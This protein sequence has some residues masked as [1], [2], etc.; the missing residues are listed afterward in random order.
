MD[1]RI[2]SSDVALLLTIFLL[3]LAGLMS[4]QDTLSAASET[5]SSLS[6]GAAT[7]KPLVSSNQKQTDNKAT[8]VAANLAV[9]PVAPGPHVLPAAESV[10]G[11]NE[12]WKWYA[13]S[14]LVVQ[15]YPGLHA[16]YS[17]PNSLPTRGEVRETTSMD[18]YGGFR[19]WNRAEGHFDVLT[20]QGFGLNDTLGIEAFPN[21]EA[22]KAG[23]P[24]PRLNV[25]RLFVRQTINLDGRAGQELLSGDQLTLAGKQNVSR[26]TFTIGR[27]SL[28]DIFDNNAYAN[29]PR[30]QFMNWALMA[31]AAWDYPSD[32]LGYTTGAAAELNQP[33][34]ALRYGF[35]QI[36]RLRN[37]WTSEDHLFT[38]PAYRGAGDGAFW[39][40]WGMSSELE[41]RYRTNAHPGTIRFLTYLNR[42]RFGS[43]QS[44]LSVPGAD[45]SQTRAYRGKYGVGLNWEQEITRNIGLFSRL[46]WNDGRSEAWMFT[47]INHSASL[48]ISVK[49]EAWRRRE[50]TFGVAG[51]GSG[52]S[53]VNQEFLAAGGTGIL[54]G[55]GALNYGKEKLLETYYD[56]RVSRMLHAAVDYQFIDDPAF[57]RA[58]GPVTVFGTR[59]HWEF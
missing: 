59:L 36:D 28:K 50:D 12:I 13:Q 24:F 42:G 32:A 20:W 10:E 15:G 55:D 45:I 18:V 48:G 31:N 21:G 29:D 11:E 16:K 44:A 2:A 30:K 37:A 33:N 41:R 3:T 23:T 52:I 5:P 27:F 25:A 56:F 19:L 40:S 38:W 34:W 6:G 17:G 53:R 22:Y 1:R 43:Y 8:E 39:R 7:A 9:T 51:V 54:A 26:L 4:A 14:T 49:G 47:D 46:G 57:N 35:F 58:R